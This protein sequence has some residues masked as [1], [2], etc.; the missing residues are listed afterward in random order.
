MKKRYCIGGLLLLVLLFAGCS[1]FRSEPEGLSM[2][3]YFLA[4]DAEFDSPTG[5]LGVETRTFEWTQWPTFDE[6]LNVYFKGPQEDG[7]L[8]PFPAGLECLSTSLDDGVLT[9]ILSD[10]FSTLTGINQSI[11]SACLTNTLTQFQNVTGVCLET[12]ANPE[13][14]HDTVVL[15]KSDFVLQDIGAVNTETTVR[16]YFADSNGRYLVASD[17]TGYF[18]EAAQIP[19]FVIQQLISGPTESGQLAVMPE[20]TVLRDIVVDSSGNCTVNLSSEFLLN[21]PATELMERMTI[22]SIVNSLTELESVKTVSFLVEGEIAP[23]SY[24]M[25]L[26]QAFVRDESAIDVVRPSMQETDATLYVS[27][28]NGKHL[29]AVPICIRRTAQAT[30]EEVLLQELLDFTA[31]NGLEPPLPEDTMIQS[32]STHSEICHVDLS[33]QFLDC[34]GDPDAETMAIRSITATLCSLDG[35]SAVKLSVNGKSNGFRYYSLEKA[36]APEDSWFQ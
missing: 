36:Y 15:A 16:L 33:S 8:S 17:R 4:A 31:I 13:A 24:H 3:L 2:D 19:A 9:V 28:M 32:I 35:V 12:R 27:G 25:D 20:G 10:A 7:L 22:L 14:E 23:E 30:L 18:T 1:L 6:I 29:S 26:S 11:A 34:A 21:K 5:A